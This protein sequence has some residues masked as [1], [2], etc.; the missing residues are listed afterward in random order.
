M[1]VLK[2]SSYFFPEQV[3]SSHLSRDLYE[4]YKSIGIETE[5]YVPTP[6]RGLD[7]ATIEKYK[8]ILE[9]KMYDGTVTV[10]RFPAMREGHNILLRALRYIIV[11]I[12]Q[13]ARGIKAKDVDVIYAGSTPPT[14]GVLCALVKKKLSKRY[15]RNV[16]LV[17]SLQDVFPDSLVNAH[18]T[19][20]GS[21]L[22]KIGRRI[23][24]YT[25]RNADRIIVISEGIK[26]NIIR[27]KASPEKITVIPNWIDTDAVK[28]VPRSENSLFSE[29]G[30]DPKTFYVTYAGNLGMAQ[31][32]DTI[33]E[34]AK[35]LQAES[36]I[37]FIIFGGGTKQDYYKAQ[38]DQMPN[39]DLYPL[40]PP[41]RVSEVYS[42]GD[43]S[44]VSCKRG[45][46]GSAL[47]SKTLSIMATGTPVVL[48]YDRGSDLWN[49]IESYDC[50]FLA[51]AD[52]GEA[53]ARQIQ[54]AYENS[55]EVQRRGANGLD[56]VMRSF[57][58]QHGTEEHIKLLESVV[59][60]HNNTVSCQS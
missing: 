11:N 14:Q 20:E 9:E 3:P 16:P 32:I 22:W 28:P 46:G 30:L 53:L 38:V 19:K 5:V 55:S 35:L 34:A 18:I 47:P 26:A 27:K 58:K 7:A 54:Y 49:L 33:L 42:L 51:D 36:G 2:L 57:S 17:F 13:Y 12:K 60:N 41:E 25:Y 45:V 10:H 52:D 40:Q 56:L 48:S 37:R 1:K 8:N 59:G 39:V 4:T 44:I 31:G 23:E 21:L 15:G 6:S 50:G 29:L 43:V 24:D